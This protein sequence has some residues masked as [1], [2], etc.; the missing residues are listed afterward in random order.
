V[1]PGFL[2]E[3]E[4]E[5]L[6]E[7]YERNWTT[8]PA[9]VVVDDLVTGARKALSAVTP[10]DGRHHFK[11]NDLYLTEPAVRDVT[12]S[13][14]L[15]KVLAELL[16]DEPVICNTLNFDRG[17][18][19]PDHLDTLYMT[20]QTTVGLVA[21]WL[22]LEDVTA[23]S[24]PLRYWPGSN[25]I[26][27]LRFSTGSLHVEQAEMGWWSEAMA[28]EVERRGL[29]QQR[30]LARRGDLF[31]WHALLLH[32]GSAIADPTT[33]R[34]SLVTHY[35]TRSDLAA[36]HVDLQPCAGGWWMKKPPLAADPS[37]AQAPAAGAAP[38]LPA[39]G[40][41]WTEERGPASAGPVGQRSTDAEPE[42]FDRMLT[43]G[44]RD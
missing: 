2:S 3:A 15:G 1:L 10:A 31:I 23:G 13:E 6:G 36:A 39:G 33:T 7:C 18:Q 12:L 43:L 27:P 24:G 8:R 19:Q 16:G 20:P 42:L 11:T 26:E 40:D 17:S 29:E 32:G 34:Q 41:A 4:I 37:P 25:H 22:A 14:R 38:D 35:W 21:T 30:F 9:G 28:S 5:A 44:A